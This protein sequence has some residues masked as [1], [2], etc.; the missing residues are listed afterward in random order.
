MGELMPPPH[1][2]WLFKKGPCQIELSLS[3]NFCLID[4]LR[5]KFKSSTSMGLPIRMLPSNQILLFKTFEG[6]LFGIRA[7]SGG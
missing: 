5:E 4:L 1:H 2:N 3:Q 6:R 7:V